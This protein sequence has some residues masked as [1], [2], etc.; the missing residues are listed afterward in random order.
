MKTIDEI[1]INKGYAETQINN[2][3]DKFVEEN[4]IGIENICFNT[5]KTEYLNQNSKIIVTLEL[6]I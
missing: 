5:S 2:I 4:N 6:R 3:L 1:R